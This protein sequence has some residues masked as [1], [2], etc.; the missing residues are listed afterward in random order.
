MF[1]SQVLYHITYRWIVKDVGRKVFDL[2]LVWTLHFA[3]IYNYNQEMHHVFN[4]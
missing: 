4:T 1:L 3:Y 2:E